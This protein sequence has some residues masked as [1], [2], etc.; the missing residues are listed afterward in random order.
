MSTVA[1]Q[2]LLGQ[3]PEMVQSVLGE[4]RFH[5]PNSANQTDL[6]VYRPNYLRDIFSPADH[7]HYRNL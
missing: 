5:Q 4:P 6:Y 3:P 1:T 2:S 7:R